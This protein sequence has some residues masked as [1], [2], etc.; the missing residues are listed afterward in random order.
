MSFVKF[1]PK[2]P[3]SLCFESSAR[4]DTESV[5]Q[6][7]VQS[8]HSLDHDVLD[9]GAIPCARVPMESVQDVRGAECAFRLVGWSNKQI[10]PQK[11]FSF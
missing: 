6:T 1:I 10:K 4:N 8:R 2:L 7:S 9:T 3:V 5:L 11:N